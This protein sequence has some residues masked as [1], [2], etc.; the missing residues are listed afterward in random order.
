MDI[1]GYP[2][3]QEILNLHQP[4]FQKP[5]EQLQAHHTAFQIVSMLVLVECNYTDALL[6]VWF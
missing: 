4:A 1:S 6:M 3:I 5:T 2:V